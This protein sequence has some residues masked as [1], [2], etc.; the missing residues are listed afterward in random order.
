MTTNY[1]RG[2]EILEIN[3]KDNITNNILFTANI[4]IGSK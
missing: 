3:K 2:F 1:L 4:T